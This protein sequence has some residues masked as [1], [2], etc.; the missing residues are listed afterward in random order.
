MRKHL[1]RLVQALLQLFYVQPR[2]LGAHAATGARSASTV[3]L[4]PPA[5]AR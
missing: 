1:L 2:R 4:R 3:R 5:L